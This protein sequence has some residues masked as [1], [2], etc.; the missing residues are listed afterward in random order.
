MSIVVV[1]ALEA[2]FSGE[3]FLFYKFSE[4]VIVYQTEEILL[5]FKTRYGDALLFYT[6]DEKQ[7]INL[8]LVNGT[9]YISTFGGSMQEPEVFYPAGPTT[10]L[11][12]NQWHSVNITRRIQQLSALIDGIHKSEV[13]LIGNFSNFNSRELYVGGKPDLSHL[14]GTKAK[15]NLFGCL[16]NVTLRVDDSLRL[17]ILQLGYDKSALLRSNGKIKYGECETVLLNTP[18]SLLKPEHFLTLGSLGNTR[19][20]FISVTLTTRVRDGLLLYAVGDRGETFAVEIVGSHLY[21]I[22]NDG[23]F[24]KRSKLNEEPVSDGR[25]HT[26]VIEMRAWGA[27]VKVNAS[28]YPGTDGYPKSIIVGEKAKAWNLTS[29]LFLGGLDYSR[30]NLSINPLVR[31]ATLRKAFIGC[32]ND[33]KIDGKLEDLKA[34]AKSQNIPVADQCLSNLTSCSGQA[35]DYKTAPNVDKALRFNG[36]QYLWTSVSQST[37]QSYAEELIIQFRTS[38]FYGVLFTTENQ[39][40]GDY[41]RVLI[42]DGKLLL[43][44][45]ISATVY[46][47]DLWTLTTSDKWH[48]LKLTRLN[49]QLSVTVNGKPAE[50]DFKTPSDALLIVDKLWLAPQMLLASLEAPDDVQASSMTLPFIGHIS[51]FMFNGVDYLGPFLSGAAMEKINYTC[52]LTSEP[53]PPLDV[54]SIIQSPIEILTPDSVYFTS[55]MLEFK[56]RDKSGLLLYGE[57]SVGYILMELLN[58]QLVLFYGLKGDNSQSVRIGSKNNLEKDIWHSVSMIVLPEND[59]VMVL[60]G[61]HYA[62]ALVSNQRVLLRQVHIAGASNYSA[63]SG[64]MLSTY[65][66]NGCL[67]SIELNGQRPKLL[68]YKHFYPS[69]TAGCPVSVVVAYSTL[70]CCRVFDSLLLSR[71]RL[72]VVVAYST[73]CCCRVFDS[74]LLSRIRHSVVVAYSTICCCRVF[75]S[76]LLSRIRLSV[77]VAYSTLLCCRVFDYLLLSRIRLSVVV[78]YSTLRCCRVFDSLLLSRNRLSV[79]VAYSTLCCCRVFDSLLLSRIRLSVVVAYSTLCLNRDQVVPNKIICKFQQSKKDYCKEETCAN[80]GECRQLLDYRLYCECSKTTYTGPTCFDEPTVYSFGNSGKR[81]IYTFSEPTD[82]WNDTVALRLSTTQYITDVLNITSRSPSS[83]YVELLVRR[84][85]IIVRY[86]LGG[87]KHS[88]IVLKGQ[89]INDGK[90]HIIRLERYGANA[91]LFVDEFENSL[92]PIDRLNVVNLESQVHIGGCNGNRSLR[93]NIAGLVINDEDIFSHPEKITEVPCQETPVRKDTAKPISSVNPWDEIIIDSSEDEICGEPCLVDPGYEITI[94]ET[95]ISSYTPT[96]SWRSIAVVSTTKNFHLTKSSSKGIKTP[97]SV[98][99]IDLEKISTLPPSS[100]FDIME[101]IPLLAGICG[102][103]FVT[104]IIILIIACRLTKKSSP[105]SKACT[106]LPHKHAEPYANGVDP[107]LTSSVSISQ[108]HPTKEWSFVRT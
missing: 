96:D 33:M 108:T 70:C 103:V 107:D 58:G 91:T 46:E 74:P 54:V 4:E 78:A 60:D 99:M 51:A 20:K 17:N 41:M 81:L 30:P 68:E 100:V 66:F 92:H 72:F 21:I 14:P 39:Q 28:F 82:R 94:P 10:R 27:G 16:K 37:S 102:A 35:C 106:T 75:D 38:H 32:L 31:T 44:Y 62:E 9:L 57:S 50:K 40:T 98:S 42:N 71:I 53:L 24:S 73:L 29:P 48:M 45:N 77:V 19:N 25:T 52:E 34:I 104:F 97:P 76:L 6:G 79:V 36:S 90:Y 84:G 18:I 47:E 2:T 22:L 87:R 93:G 64:T 63:L 61:V 13:S 80:G 88:L 8:G 43:S 23:T 69:I 95:K 49:K 105:P 11:D 15:K 67:G 65:G 1:S 83:D 5:D 56:P 89:T 7:Y 59:V 85:R 12:D 101:N 26:L 86:N 3:E 55:F